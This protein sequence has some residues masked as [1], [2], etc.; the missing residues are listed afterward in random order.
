MYLKMGFPIR[1]ISKWQW[2]WWFGGYQIEDPDLSRT[3]KPARSSYI[4]DPAPGGLSAGCMDRGLSSLSLSR[5]RSRSR[6][7]RVDSMSVV[8]VGCVGC[9][10]WVGW[11]G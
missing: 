9:V 3:P 10:G 11:V 1:R 8:C 4:Q 7:R 2:W 5:S 6:S